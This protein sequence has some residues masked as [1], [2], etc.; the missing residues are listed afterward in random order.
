MRIVTKIQYIILFIIGLLIIGVGSAVT[1]TNIDTKPWES[2]AYYLDIGLT[3]VAIIVIITATMLQQMDYYTS[4]NEEYIV[5]EKRIEEYAKDRF[6]PSKFNKYA[7]VANRTRKKNQMLYL[8]RK[9]LAEVDKSMREKDHNIWSFG[10]PEQKKKNKK[11]AKRLRFEQ[12]LQEIICL[13]LHCKDPEI[14]KKNAQILQ[15]I[16]NKNIQYD[17][18]TSGVILGGFY[19]REE[20]EQV[21]DFVSKNKAW[22]VIKERGPLLLLGLGFTTLTSTFVLNIIFTPSAIVPILTKLIVLLWQVI[23]IMRYAKGYFQK[24]YLKDIRWRKGV[25]EECERWLEQEEANFTEAEKLRRKLLEEGVIKNV[26]GNIVTNPVG[27]PTPNAL[28]LQ[29]STNNN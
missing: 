20:N 19:S 13:D 11:C 9:G 14:I 10:T 26:N 27:V 5:D 4:T 25:I 3:Y 12:E 15:T 22:T 21:N 28:Y 18:I 16:E 17:R 8:L 1:G 2:M 24:T 23:L 6:L 7:L 29:P